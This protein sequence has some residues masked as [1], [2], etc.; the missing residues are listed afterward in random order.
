MS[1]KPKKGDFLYVVNI[2]N[3][4]GKYC[5][6]EKVGRSYFYLREMPHTRFHNDDWSEESGFRVDYQVYSSLGE[7]K[8]TDGSRHLW[9]KIRAIVNRSGFQP[10]EKVSA[11]DLERIAEILGVEG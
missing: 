6:V 1:E 2:R 9:N 10:P 5:T 11:S 8:N 3:Y 4:E 7:Y